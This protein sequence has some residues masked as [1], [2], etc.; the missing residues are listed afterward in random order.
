[1]KT[2]NR[3]FLLIRLNTSPSDAGGLQEWELPFARTIPPC[4]VLSLM[5]NLETT[6][7]TS[8]LPVVSIRQ[9]I[10]VTA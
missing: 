8:G 2:V 10:P 4:S 7:V 9:T 3:P 6:G 1:M 5:H